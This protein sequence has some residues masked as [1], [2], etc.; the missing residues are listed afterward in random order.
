MSIVKRTTKGVPLTYEE[1]DGNFTDLD[2]R[3]IAIETAN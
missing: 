3:I 1:L 2:T